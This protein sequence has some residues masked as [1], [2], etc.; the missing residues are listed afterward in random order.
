MDHI[1]FIKLFRSSLDHPLYMPIGEPF[2]RW[3]AWIDLLLMANYKTSQQMYKGKM[4][5]TFPGQIQTSMLALSKRWGWSFNKVR[6]FL[7]VLES[8]QMIT[9]KRTTD[10]TT[11]TVENWGKF[12]IER[13]TNRQTDGSQTDNKKITDD[14]H[15]KKIKKDNKLNNPLNP[16][17]GEVCV[18]PSSPEFDPAADEKTWHEFLRNLGKD[19][20][21]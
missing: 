13:I 10:G 8:E 14:T 2:D 17:Q 1:G 6:R 7:S 20:H 21:D 11:I 16:P 3:H 19:K 4:Q 18:D 5:T 15:Y 12:Q 9:L